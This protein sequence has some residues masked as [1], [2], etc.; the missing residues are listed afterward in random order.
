MNNNIETIYSN[1]NE[2]GV[3]FDFI[4]QSKEDS[5]LTKIDCFSRLPSGWD[6]GQGIGT[7]KHVSKK[8]KDIYLKVKKHVYFDMDYDVTPMTD[9]GLTVIFSNGNDFI[10]ISIYEDLSMDLVWE[11]GIGYDFDII[12]EKEK[13]GLPYI[14]HVIFQLHQINSCVLSEHSLYLNMHQEKEDSKVI[15]SEKTTGESLY[16]TKHALS[17]PAVQYAFT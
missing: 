14:L 17:L 10:N 9:G 11:R 13:V 5:I 16:L 2:L 1:Q 15:H 3:H 4:M 8:A 12:K 6:F 7:L